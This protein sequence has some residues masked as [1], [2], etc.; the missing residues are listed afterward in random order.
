MEPHLGHQLG[1][2]G[3]ALADRKRRGIRQ[4]SLGDTQLVAGAL[5]KLSDGHTCGDGVR[6]HDEI[7]TDTLGSKREVLF[8]NNGSDRALLSVT[9]CKLVTQCGRTT[10][11][12]PNANTEQAI[13]GPLAIHGI[14]A[15]PLSALGQH[16]H[17][18]I[19]L[20]A[21]LG[22]QHRR[23]KAHQHGL[24]G[25]LRANLDN[26]VS[27]QLGVIDI[28]LALDIQPLVRRQIGNLRMRLTTDIQD[29]LLL[30]L[31]VKV[32]GVKQATL[33]GTLIHEHGVL[34]IESAVHE[35]GDHHVLSV[36]HAPKGVIL[37]PRL[38][39]W[40]AWRTQN[41]CHGIETLLEVGVVPAARLLLLLSRREVVTGSGVV[42]RKRHHR[43]G[44]S[45]VVV[46]MD[47]GNTLGVLRNHRNHQGIR[48]LSIHPIEQSL[49]G[50]PRL[51]SLQAVRGDSWTQNRT[52]RTTAIA[53]DGVGVIQAI[54]SQGHKSVNLARSTFFQ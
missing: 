51:G 46:G 31:G 28:R 4:G 44:G 3:N 27:I 20:H 21:S 23:H 36:G 33:Q 17:V 32:G 7:R 40:A 10:L 30:S 53:P 14:H 37:H 11:R 8:R 26:A 41:C 24:G 13:R 39:Q 12:Q 1:G 49:G 18:T 48:L 42:V 15:T 52:H 35:N 47:L 22:I 45:Q 25:D 50:I 16:T 9:R 2:I 6:V 34:L 43:R 29:V 54:P 38:R 5:Q 19:G